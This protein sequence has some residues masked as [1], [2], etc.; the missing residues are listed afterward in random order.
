LRCS[1]CRAVTEED[2]PK[3][4]EQDSDRITKEN[5]MEK[6]GYWLRAA[7]QRWKDHWSVYKKLDTKP[8]L[9]IMAEKNAYADALGEHLWKTKEYGFNQSEVLVIHTDAAGE[10]A[11]SL[12]LHGTNKRS[13]AKRI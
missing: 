6:Y 10:V 7:V 2:D 12:N 8:V 9:F 3:Q 13:E 4:P 1:D 5:V 11:C